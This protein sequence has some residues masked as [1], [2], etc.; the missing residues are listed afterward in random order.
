M[1]IFHGLTI[2]DWE[3]M[4]SYENQDGFYPEQPPKGATMPNSLLAFA[5]SLN[6][7]VEGSAE[8]DTYFHPPANPAMSTRDNSMNELWLD[9]FMPLEQFTPGGDGVP[10]PSVYESTPVGTAA[11]AHFSGADVHYSSADG[12][13]STAGMHYAS[14]DPVYS[15]SDLSYSVLLTPESQHSHHYPGSPQS[16]GTLDGSDISDLLDDLER[17]PNGMYS[18]SPT[19][20]EETCPLQF[21]TLEAL[22]SS[23]TKAGYVPEYNPAVPPMTLNE[24]LGVVSAKDIGGMDDIEKLLQAPLLAQGPIPKV[25]GKRRASKDGCTKPDKKQRKKDQ[26][27]TAAVRYRQRKREEQEALDKRQ[28][29]LLTE[30]K[31]LRGEVDGLEREILYLRGLMEEVR[32]RRMAA[33]Y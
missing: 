20:A 11:S 22:L 27:K 10:L 3:K 26:N 5:S 2:S 30:N 29:K 23:P 25:K 18:F 19:A 21:S 6:S 15:P 33:P 16:Q 12:L 1:E 32:K 9:E 8:Y 14:A 13:Y 28:D 17:D 24:Q 31:R 7:D 4:E